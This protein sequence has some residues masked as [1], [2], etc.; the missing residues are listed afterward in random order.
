[1]GIV[2]DSVERVGDNYVR[3]AD[4]LDLP[5][6][7]QVLKGQV[8]QIEGLKKNLSNLQSY[9]KIVSVVRVQDTMVVKEIIEPMTGNTTVHMEF[10]DGFNKTIVTL[11]SGRAVLDQEIRVPL[12]LVLY[13]QRKGIRLLGKERLRIGRK[14]F[15]VAARSDNPKVHV[16]EL[17][18]LTPKKYAD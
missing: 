8:D 15:M 16:K 10:N 12:Q 17:Y 7:R 1:M 5:E 6:V 14:E 4:V 11:D 3:R 2:Q 18:N 13:Y 9:T